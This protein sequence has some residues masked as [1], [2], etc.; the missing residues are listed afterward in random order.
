MRI[1]FSSFEDR[2][3][4]AGFRGRPILLARLR[5]ARQ[6]QSGPFEVLIPNWTGS[7]EVSTN[8]LVM[9]LDGLPAWTA[10]KE[11]DERLFSGIKSAPDAAN[12][13]M[14]PILMR[15]IRLGVDLDFGDAFEKATAREERAVTRIDEQRSYLEILAMFGR[16]YSEVLGTP[17]LRHVSAKV[18]MHLMEADERELIRLVRAISGAVVKGAGISREAL[19]DRLDGLSSFAAPICSLVTQD[20]SRSVGYL[21]RQQAMLER[22]V[23]RLR[24]HA[25]AREDEVGDAVRVID[26]NASSFLAYVE[27]KAAAIRAAVL[28]EK[29]YLNAA[30]HEALRATIAQERIRISFALDGWADHAERWLTVMGE[31]DRAKDQAIGAILRDMP[32]PTREIEGTM[33]SLDR[34]RGLM[35]LRTAL[36]KELHS[37]SDDQID[38]E[39]AERV[40]RGRERTG[41]AR[42]TAAN[43]ISRWEKADRAVHNALRES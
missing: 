33:Q 28:N 30:A 25:G 34:G 23:E 4:F 8:D 41:Q 18:L 27:E 32:N 36:V 38:A 11:R 15:E 10:L 21:S 6:P 37:W 7:R 43:E 19:T 12:G 29:A 9:P 26:L 1:R 5:R 13:H 17:E 35:S 2:G 3:V 22:L 40:R 24:E 20:V 14:D 39:L 42:P 16:A 31:D